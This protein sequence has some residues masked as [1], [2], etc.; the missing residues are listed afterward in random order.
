MQ[1]GTRQISFTPNSLIKIAN[2]SYEYN[3]EPNKVYYFEYQS[4][5][6]KEAAEKAVESHY[7]MLL[8]YHLGWVL[9][10]EPEAINKL[11]ALKAWQ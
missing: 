6:N 10:E 2:L 9:L 11:K 5:N 4:F 8:G 3:F 7:N 1:P